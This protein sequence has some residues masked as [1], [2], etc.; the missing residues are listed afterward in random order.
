MAYS[1]VEQGRLLGRPESGDVAARHGATPAQI[2][3]AWLLRQEGVVVIPKAGTQAH[4]RENR[5]AL[6]L[7]LTEADLRESWTGPSRRPPARCRWRCSEQIR[8]AAA[9]NQ[10]AR[11]GS[12]ERRFHPQPR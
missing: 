8:P 3:L 10:E 6:D 9:M 7:R 11:W 2:A 5:G 1:P 4:V 12:D